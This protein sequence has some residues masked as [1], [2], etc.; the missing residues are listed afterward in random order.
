LLRR[1]MDRIIEPLGAMGARIKG[2]GERGVFAPL[3]IM[4]GALNGI[5]YEMPIASAQVKSALL[6]AGLS[7]KGETVVIEPVPSRDHTERMLGAMGADIHIR[8]NSISIRPSTIQSI[9]VTV[10]GDFSSAAYWIAAGCLHP[11]ADVVVRNVGVNRYRTGLIRTLLEM[12]ADIVFENEAV[13]GGEPVADIRARTS[14]LKGVEVMGSIIPWLVDELP[15]VALIGAF[16]DGTTTI[17]DA[18]EL[19]VKETDRIQTTTA[20]LSKMGIAIE[21]LFDGMLVRQSKNLS[22]TTVSS[23]GDH[24]LAMTLGIA[25]LLMD[26]QTIVMEADA[27]SVTYPGFWADLDM[28]SGVGS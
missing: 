18:T 9:N 20:Q 13:V 8:D 28:L 15:I 23:C 6:I 27:A 2:S 10:P 16:A 11:D 17:R 3:E 4:G 26:G 12:G 21:E 22:G 5:T 7:A 25:G 24:R 14:R 19:R 1:P